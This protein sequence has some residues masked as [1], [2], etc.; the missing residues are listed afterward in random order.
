MLLQGPVGPF[1]GKLHQFLNHMGRD[2]WRVCFHRA[3]YL[4]HKSDKSLSFPGGEADWRAW[5]SAV[6]AARAFSTIIL[7]GAQRP[8][9][10]V[11]RN[12]AK[13]YGVRVI[14]LEEGYI[15]PG[16]ITVEN[17]GNN[18]SSPIAGQLPPAEEIDQIDHYPQHHYK[19]LSRM[20]AYA[21]LYYTVRGLTTYRKQRALFHRK[22]PL[23]T[24]A[25]YWLRNIAR[26]I[27]CGD[28][29]FTIIQNL[30]EHADRQYFLV[31]LQVNA[32]ANMV[33]FSNGW[34][35]VR[36]IVESLRSFAIYAP[37]D[38]RLVFK[39][40]PMERGHNNLTTLITSTAEKLGLTDRV[41][42]VETGSLGLL[43]RHSA[44]M[45]TINSSSGLSA[46]FHGVPLLVMGRAIY[47][48][49]ALAQCGNDERDFNAFWTSQH[50]A[51]PELRANY[52]AWLKRNALKA[53]D[54]YHHDGID[55]ACQSVF[56]KL[57]ERVP[58]APIVYEKTVSLKV[59][60]E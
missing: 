51:K 54:F 6:L 25:F 22:T 26:R 53:G 39:I 47:R 14:C 8:A 17:D 46:V 32:D 24:E 50:V 31:P 18:A 13:Q 48:H 19:G 5:L 29:N 43:T 7:F 4:H 27:C 23:A 44:G 59:A 30:L 34:T 2:T 57:Q 15:R 55:V 52:L 10:I 9:H 60:A 42:V 45:I 38:L 12:V 49:P 11:A 36:L 41:D 35:S 28:R 20:V 58:E 33:K 40:H 1:F 21:C 3:D 16:Y 56:E 37:P